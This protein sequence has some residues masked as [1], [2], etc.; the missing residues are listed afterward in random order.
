[1][2]YFVSP[3]SD[4]L[5]T[6]IPVF[7]I[8]RLQIVHVIRGI[9][10]FAVNTH[11]LVSNLFELNW[12]DSECNLFFYKGILLKFVSSQ[13]H[14]WVHLFEHPKYSHFFYKL[15]PFLFSSWGLLKFYDILF[16]FEIIFRIINCLFID[17]LILNDASALITSCTK[18][19]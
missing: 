2:S 4:W 7:V 12:F 9:N 15:H 8:C 16:L 3:S 11:R 19:F 17:R 6:I 10:N 14:Y 1:M 18:H 13:K 5:H